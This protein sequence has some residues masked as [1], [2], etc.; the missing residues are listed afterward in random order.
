MKCLQRMTVILWRRNNFPNNSHH[1]L[2][3]FVG[4]II[5]ALLHYI[6]R[7]IDAVENKI[8]DKVVGEILENSRHSGAGG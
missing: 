2:Q 5:T 4:T 8:F 1:L 3:M 7:D 6:Y